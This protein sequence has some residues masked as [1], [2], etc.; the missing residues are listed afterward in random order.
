MCFLQTLL[1]LWMQAAA[2]EKILRMEANYMQAMEYEAA[3]ESRAKAA[4]ADVDDLQRDL[5]ELQVRMC[6]IS[7]C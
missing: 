2:E 7:G 1:R 6:L 5:L 4:Q 3:A